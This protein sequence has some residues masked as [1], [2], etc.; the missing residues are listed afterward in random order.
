[1]AKMS[2]QLVVGKNLIEISV[3]ALEPDDPSPQPA[4]NTVNAALAGLLKITDSDGKITRIPLNEAWSGRLANTPTWQP[5]T[6]AGGLSDP[7]FGKILPGS[8]PQPAVL[9]R[10]RFNVSK[11]VKVA[12]LYATALGSYRIF[13]NNERVGQDVLTPTSPTT[14]SASSTRLTM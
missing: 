6:V 9:L 2:Q 11:A 7:Q 10:K 1:M 13:L 8:L 12:R 14:P 5:A 3:T 4:S